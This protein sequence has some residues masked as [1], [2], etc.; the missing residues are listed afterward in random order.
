M[1]HTCKENPDRIRQA[2]LICDPEK[3]GRAFG[4]E[5]TMS[6]FLS[7]GSNVAPFFHLLF[8]RAALPSLTAP[9]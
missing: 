9:C 4:L 7:G 3:C 5:P 6:S 1:S 8:L 2:V